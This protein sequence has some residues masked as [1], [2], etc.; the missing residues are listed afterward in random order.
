MYDMFFGAASL[1]TF[2]MRKTALSDIAAHTHLLE[3]GT[4]LRYIQKLFAVTV[5]KPLKSIHMFVK[6]T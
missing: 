2:P 6:L 5:V 1:I 3:N 4:N